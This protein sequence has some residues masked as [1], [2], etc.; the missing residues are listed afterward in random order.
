MVLSEPLLARGELAI[1]DSTRL[2]MDWPE[3]GS[4]FF[5][6][7]G[8]KRFIWHPQVH[9][10]FK[11]YCH[12]FLLSGQRGSGVRLV[13]GLT[14]LF[15]RLQLTPSS[16][17]IVYGTYDVLVR[18]WLTDAA[19]SKFR[20]ALRTS[21][22]DLDIE[23]YLEFAA[24]E[25]DYGWMAQRPAA[26]HLSETLLWNHREQIQ[27]VADAESSR[28]W[29]EQADTDLQALC[30]SGLVHLIAPPDALKYY[31]FLTH[32]K[33]NS[34]LNDYV[35]EVLRDRAHRAETDLDALTI[36]S[37]KGFCDY[38]LKSAASDYRSILGY[39]QSFQDAA[40][41]VGLRAWSLVPADSGSNEE[42]E[43]LDGLLNK[44][45]DALSPLLSSVTHPESIRRTILGM[46][47]AQQDSLA[48]V[49]T[50]GCHLLA[51]GREQD[52]FCELLEAV[53]AN[54]RKEI[55]QVLSFLTSLEGD[56]RYV[57]PRIAASQGQAGIDRMRGVLARLISTRSPSEDAG[58][59]VEP[60]GYVQRA[61]L[62]ELMEVMRDL[63]EGFAAVG[64]LM[65]QKLQ[66]GWQRQ[67]RLTV[68]LRNEYAHSRLTEKLLGVDFTSAPAQQSLRDLAHA[69]RFQVGMEHLR[70]EIEATGVVLPV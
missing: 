62:S 67:T 20:E 38:V 33:G 37:G 43:A 45:P 5:G 6:V 32:T 27:R 31:V 60:K 8:Q 42:G 55:N 58:N 65:D 29:S 23:A 56:V 18:I 9:E 41:H 21:D 7:A 25:I 39:V 49:Y 52:R 46:P 64:A 24:D 50:D 17:S 3:T 16:T 15:G 4:R 61:Y 47:P 63:A 34:N 22:R 19:R 69:I 2:L 1:L 44:F 35:V 40:L 12:I 13:S 53:M 10:L 68:D 11:E 36:Y 59:A 57:L 26:S 54:Q 28:R 48:S 51:A 70:D 30:E 66:P 14:D